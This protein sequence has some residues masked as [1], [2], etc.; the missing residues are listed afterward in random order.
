MI[1]FFRKIRRSLIAQNKFPKYLL[2]AVGE[3]ILVVIGILIALQ[4]NNY[5]EYQKERKKEWVLLSN[6]S[7]EVQLDMLQI[8][9]NTRLTTERLKRLDSLVQLLRAPDSINALQ[10][11]RQSYEFV[12]DQYFKSNSGIFDEAVSSGKMSYIQNEPLRQRIFNYYR[13]VKESYID[14]TARQITD[15]FITPLLIEHVYLNQEGFTMLG[16][17]VED[18]SIIE[19][20]NVYQLT[21]NKDYWKM[22]L[23]KFGANQEQILRWKGT[24][25]RAEEL[26]QQIDLELKKLNQ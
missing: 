13:N 23:M 1:K 10:F 5:S 24:R 4:I 25:Q 15:E 3:I 11:I 21:K 19:E 7:Q 22:V 12:F 8:E 26:K 9:N 14:G 6:L 16:M 18:I 20:L 2:Y 17:D